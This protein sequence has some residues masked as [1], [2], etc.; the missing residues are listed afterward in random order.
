MEARI[1]LLE[2]RAPDVR[3]EGGKD[4]D[5]TVCSAEEGAAKGVVVASGFGTA[6]A[7]PDRFSRAERPG[8]F[9]PFGTNPS[10]SKSPITQSGRSF[11]RRSSSYPPSAAITKSS[12]RG[13]YAA[14]RLSPDPKITQRRGSERILTFQAG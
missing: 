14:P 6:G 12:I 4:G 1:A 5:Q 9:F 2:G 10:E 3:E 8:H 13:E 11:R 7:G